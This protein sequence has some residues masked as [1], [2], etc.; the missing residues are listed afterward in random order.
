MEHKDIVK[1]EDVV[2]GGDDAAGHDTY[3]DAC[4]EESSPRATLCDSTQPIAAAVPQVDPQKQAD[5]GSEGMSPPAS[6]VEGGAYIQAPR[7]PTG[8]QQTPG[9]PGNGAGN[10]P[11]GF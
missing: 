5:V 8:G 3:L 6:G 7:A 4:N 2:D 10:C 11:T 1:S 9:R